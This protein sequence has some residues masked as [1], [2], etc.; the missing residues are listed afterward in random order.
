[1]L[2]LALLLTGTGFVRRNAPWLGFIGVF[3]G[4]IGISMFID[5]LQGE[6]YFPLHIFGSL[7]LAES[8][9]TLML[10][11]SGV[12]AQKAVLYFKGGIF[13]FVALLILSGRESSNLLLAVV[14]GFAFLITGLFVMAAAWVVRYQHWPTACLGG[15]CRFLFGIYLIIPYPTHHQ[16]IVSQFIGMIMILSGIHCL[17]LALRARRIREGDSIFHLLAPGGLLPPADQ[18]RTEQIP[19]PPQDSSP[20]IV[21]VWTPEGSADNTP[22]PRPVFNRYIA[23]VDTNGVISTGHAA[24][25][26]HPDLYISLYPAEDIDRSPS[27]FFNT[28]KAI[29][30]NNV[31]GDFQKN[32]VSEAAAWCESDRKVVFHDFNPAA[33]RRYW[34]S[35][36]QVEIYN[37]TWRNCSS[38]V[39]YALE[40]ALD[41]VFA[42]RGGWLSFLR[43][44][45]I[46]ELWIASQL[47]KRAMT[48][49]WTPGL[50]LDYARA[51]HAIVHPVQ[52]SWLRRRR[53][54][55]AS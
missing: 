4:G 35:Y 41:G 31:A 6:R 3:W 17:R 48:M 46:P 34:A 22:I 53:H 38:S 37:L 18:T 12:G 29:Q 54:D 25:E 42:H 50:A 52:L 15:F 36:R 49:A 40:A 19:E 7:L 16:G 51:L 47:R 5:G 43:L 55:E 13:C 1:M 32:Y 24:L 30:D 27:E 8:L 23:A 11:P 21:H 39:A 2:Q 20:L 26:M 28:L 10:A 14:F 9:I 45:L 33:L 44:F